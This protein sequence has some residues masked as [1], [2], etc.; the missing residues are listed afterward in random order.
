[1]A[2]ISHSFEPFKQQGLR[3]AIS[4]AG[5]FGVSS[6]ATIKAEVERLAIAATVLMVLLL[7][8]ALGSLRGLAT[9]MLP[10]ATG[11]LAGIAAV[12]LGFGQ[13]HGITLGFGTTLIGEAVDYAIYYLIQAQAGKAAIATTNG[14]VRADLPRRSRKNSLIAPRSPAEKVECSIA[15]RVRRVSSRKASRPICT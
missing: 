15:S 12:S 11:V 2:L 14:A 9:A 6:R 10:V 8:A 5:S 7:W 3:L 1:M 4:G 13:V